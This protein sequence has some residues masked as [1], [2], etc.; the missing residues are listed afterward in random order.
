MHSGYTAIVQLEVRGLGGGAPECVRLKSAVMAG[1]PDLPVHT[2]PLSR[3][4]KLLQRPLLCAWT[5]NLE[6]G[7]LEAG[8]RTDVGEARPCVE[9]GLGGQPRLH[10]SGLRNSDEGATGAVFWVSEGVRSPWECGSE[11]RVESF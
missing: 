4:I 10:G 11:T 1:G 7:Q 6:L 5:P 3:C 2:Y 9:A 8:W